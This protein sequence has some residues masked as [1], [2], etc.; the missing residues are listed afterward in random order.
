MRGVPNEFFP[1]EGEELVA[2][3]R[4]ERRSATKI[5]RLPD[6]PLCRFPTLVEPRRASLATLGSRQEHGVSA[7]SLSP[8]L[9]SSLFD[10]K[11]AG[12]NNS[13]EV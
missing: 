2:S 13:E 7:C 3:G 9:V 11:P 5:G 1:G 10:A 6:M 4:S 8:T 12:A